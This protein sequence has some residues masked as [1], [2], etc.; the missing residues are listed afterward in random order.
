[1]HT[2]NFWKKNLKK[3]LVEHKLCLMQKVPTHVTKVTTVKV[4]IC[5]NVATM[6][7]DGLHQHFMHLAKFHV[8]SLSLPLYAIN[9]KN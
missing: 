2:G 9:L 5:R 7:R 8:L 1:M 3:A 6:I 4:L